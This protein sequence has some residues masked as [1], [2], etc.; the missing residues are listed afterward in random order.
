M[1]QL[2]CFKNYLKTL[3]PFIKR[4]NKEP[5]FTSGSQTQRRNKLQMNEILN[6]V[7]KEILQ[8]I[9]KKY[10][11]KITK[12]EIEPANSTDTESDLIINICKEPA[13]QP[14]KLAIYK[15]KELSHLSD[16]AYQMFI[17]AGTNL[18]SLR[19]TKEC[20]FI[21]NSEFKSDSND[22]GEFYYKLIVYY[23]NQISD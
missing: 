2:S 16:K 5:H 9:F 13:H 10:K 22:Y 17:N 3:F 12:I 23:L 18:P 21:L 19:F 4:E 6:W 11:L 14:C 15:Q 8:S 20:A 7:Y 1:N